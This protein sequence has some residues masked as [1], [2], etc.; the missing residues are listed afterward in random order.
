MGRLGGAKLP[1]GCMRQQALLRCPCL[2]SL[3]ALALGTMVWRSSWVGA[4]RDSA[5]LQ[6]GGA[7]RAGG[8]RV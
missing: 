3:K 5:R 6:G 1:P 7:N 4:C 8:E 2:S